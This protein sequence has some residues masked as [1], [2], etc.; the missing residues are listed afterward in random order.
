MFVCNG[1]RGARWTGNAFPGSP[2]TEC[3]NWNKDAPKV[4]DIHLINIK[5]PH[6]P[7]YEL[8]DSCLSGNPFNYIVIVAND[9][10]EGM[11]NKATVR[12]R[13]NLEAVSC[14]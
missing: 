7:L 11:V 6:R 14:H 13:S 8:E 5:L 10:L 1:D 3:Q 12:C 2:I 9:T 4:H